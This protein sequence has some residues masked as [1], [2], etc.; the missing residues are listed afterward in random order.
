MAARTQFDD[1][2]LTRKFTVEQK[3]PGE[4]WKVIASFDDYV[5]AVIARARIT[6]ILRIFDSELLEKRPEWGDKTGKTHDN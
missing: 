5:D 2:I 3:L 4:G 1:G 6:P